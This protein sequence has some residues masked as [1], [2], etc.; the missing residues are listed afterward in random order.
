MN[1]LQPLHKETIGVDFDAK[2]MIIFV[3]T[4]I[5]VFYGNLFVKLYSGRIG[6]DSSVFELGGEN[7]CCVCEK[8]VIFVE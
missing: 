8:N 1:P 3:F 5:F 4:T 6:G 7:N 2:L